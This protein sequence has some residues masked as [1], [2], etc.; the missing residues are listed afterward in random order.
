MRTRLERPSCE[1]CREDQ[2]EDGLC[3]VGSCPVVPLPVEAGRAMRCWKTMNAL[4]DL[5]GGGGAAVAAYGLREFDLEL[6]ALIETE[7]RRKTSGAPV[8]DADED[9]GV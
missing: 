6:L 4:R 9:E 7:V 5:P 8:A 3:V 2:E 1:T